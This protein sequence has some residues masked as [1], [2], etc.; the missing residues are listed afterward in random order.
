MEYKGQTLQCSTLGNNITELIF[1][2]QDGSVN[3]L[4]ETRFM[5]SM[6]LLSSWKKINQ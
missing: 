1:D 5:N 2:F 6:K 4:I 3:S